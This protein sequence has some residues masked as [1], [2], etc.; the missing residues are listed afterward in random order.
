MAV[1]FVLSHTGSNAISQRCRYYSTKA[2]GLKAGGR[3]RR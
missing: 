3:R 2:N 1:V